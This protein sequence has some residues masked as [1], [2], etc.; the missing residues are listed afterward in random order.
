MPYG[1]ALP[2]AGV[3][4]RK[5][6]TR[7][8]WGDFAGRHVRPTFLKSPT[9]SFFLV[10]T[11]IVGCC[12]PCAARSRRAADPCVVR[13][14]HGSGHAAGQACGSLPGV[15]GAIAPTVGGD[16]SASDRQWLHCAGGACDGDV[17]VDD[18]AGPACQRSFKTPQLWSSKIPH[19]VGLVLNH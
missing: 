4:I 7:T 16:G 13:C 14:G 17:G 3:L 8:R 10:S 12:R 5:S 18:S 19:P 11:E 6:W 1:M 2:P 9:S 15:D